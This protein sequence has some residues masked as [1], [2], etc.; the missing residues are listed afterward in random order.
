MLHLELEVGDLE[1]EEVELDEPLGVEEEGE[2]C[3]LFLFRF[4]VL[5]VVVDLGIKLFRPKSI[6]DV[7]VLMMNRLI[8][9]I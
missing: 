7:D 5:L 1:L 8:M 4:L 2:V 6:L 3:F 9:R